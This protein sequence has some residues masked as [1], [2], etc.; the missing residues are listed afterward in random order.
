M[1]QQHAN[2]SM[3][4]Q[5]RWSKAV[6]W[7]NALQRRVLTANLGHKLCC[8]VHQHCGECTG[9]MSPQI[10]MSG[11]LMSVLQGRRSQHTSM[12]SCCR[13]RL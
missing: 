3:C 13:A 10:Q 6:R 2:R 1:R 9:I 11:L 4:L 8:Y 12:H 5:G 7:T